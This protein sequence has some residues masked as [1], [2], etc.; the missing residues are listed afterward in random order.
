LELLGCAHLRFEIVVGIWGCMVVRICGITVSTISQSRQRQ[1]DATLR[2]H[3]VITV[4]TIS[5]SRQ[6]QHDA[7]LRQHDV[8]T[9]IT[10]S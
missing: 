9:V 1:H 10:I 8:I 2:Q 4:S 5:K 6:R 7:T 3:D